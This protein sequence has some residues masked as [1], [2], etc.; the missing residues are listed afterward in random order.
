MDFGVQ[1][2]YGSVLTKC[3][4]L[5]MGAYVCASV[6]ASVHLSVTF[7]LNCYKLANNGWILEFKVSM[8]CFNLFFFKFSELL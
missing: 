5:F 1:G 7:F 6:C 2:V 8:K 3:F 4:N